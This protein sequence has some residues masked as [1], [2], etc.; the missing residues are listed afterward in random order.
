MIIK[1]QNTKTGT[2]YDI[3][4]LVESLTH[5]TYISDQPGKCSFTVINDPSGIFE[6]VNGSIIDITDAGKGIFHGYVF[7][8]ETS[9]DRKN[10][11]IAYDQ[12]RYLQ[13]DEVYVTSEMTA[14][15]I[16]EKVCADSLPTSIYK[17]ITPS[18]YIPETHVHKSK[19]YE[20]IKYGIERSNINEKDK[21]YIIRDN[22][23]T[24]EFTE[25][26]QLK[27]NYIIGNES[28]LTNYTYKIDID[29]NTFNTI[30]IIRDNKESG[31][32]DSWIVKDSETMAQWGT[33]QM[34]ETAG[35]EMNEAQ[36]IELA[37][38]YMKLYNRE[39]QTMKITAIGIPE[40]L[41]G[42]GFTLEVK[43]LGIKQDMW[44]TSASH[45]YKEGSH[46]MSLEVFI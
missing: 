10:K 42:N 13:N 6:I 43:E 30:K 1:C 8:M 15:Q 36:I 16:F 35:A 40:L 46:I 44:I 24:L 9:E 7:S 45:E 3:T 27:T 34:V 11:I 25:L 37:N 32:I 12:I 5:E 41:A 29:S 33:L 23:G 22:Y 14:S 26:A 28:L 19:L 20:V 4:T 38:N 17:V 39:K 21:Y 31:K 2:I 18:V